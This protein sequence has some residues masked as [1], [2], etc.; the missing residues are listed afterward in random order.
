MKSKL[1]IW[2]LQRPLFASGGVGEV[3]AYT[4]GK[5]NLALIP[6]PPEMVE[7]VFGDEP[8]V[9]VWAK[10]VKGNLSVDSYAEEQ[11]W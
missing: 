1:E 8:K 3:M 4:E 6:L 5:K 9:Y 11:A 7:E 10:V 2:K